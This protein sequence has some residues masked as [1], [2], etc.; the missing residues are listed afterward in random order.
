MG[1]IYLFNLLWSHIQ[2]DFFEITDRTKL[3]YFKNLR[4]T[5]RQHTAR[6]PSDTAKIDTPCFGSK[7]T[8]CSIRSRVKLKYPV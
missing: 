7:N 3:D 2:N 5:R 4:Y 1:K 8:P 6:S